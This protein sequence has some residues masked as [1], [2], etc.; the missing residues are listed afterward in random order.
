MKEKFFKVIT[1]MAFLLFL[2]S[3][4]IRLDDRHGALV[5]FIIMAVSAAVI[6]YMHIRNPEILEPEERRS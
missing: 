1:G 4:G 3:T 2:L 5:S 6:T